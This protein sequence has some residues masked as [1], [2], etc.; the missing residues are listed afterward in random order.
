[1][2]D[3]NAFIGSPKTSDTTNKTPAELRS[4][5]V[6]CLQEHLTGNKIELK[7]KIEAYAKASGTDVNDFILEFGALSVGAN[8]KGKYK[9]CLIGDGGVG[10]TSLV[11]QLKGEGF[12]TVYKASNGANVSNIFFWTKDGAY[13]VELWDCAGCEKVEGMGSGYFINS[14]ACIIMIDL[15]SKVSYKGLKSRHVSFTRVCANAPVVVLGNKS[16]MKERKVMPT[17]VT[18]PRR[19]HLQYYEVSVKTGRNITKG[20]LTLLRTLTRDGTMEFVNRTVEQH[21]ELEKEH[22]AKLAATVPLPREDD[23]GL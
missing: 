20:F 19:N 3:S 9:I 16:D 22:K 18:Y 4:D 8:V 21:G 13:H 11:N 15:A 23:N 6:A 10:K 1:M 7:S 12:T 2:R 17:H 14:D 5:V